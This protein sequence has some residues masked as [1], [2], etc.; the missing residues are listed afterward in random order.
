MPLLSGWP[1]SAMLWATNLKGDLLGLRSRQSLQGMVPSSEGGPS[2]ASQ[3]QRFRP[4]QIERV[5]VKHHHI[6]LAIQPPFF[7]GCF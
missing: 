6:D 4:W 7:P 3:L 5:D 1:S 2:C